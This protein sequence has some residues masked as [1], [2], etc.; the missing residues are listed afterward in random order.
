VLTCRIVVG[1]S[2]EATCYLKKSQN[3]CRQENEQLDETFFKKGLQQEQVRGEGEGED[4]G[5]PVLI[6]NA[7]DDPLHTNHSPSSSHDL[8]TLSHS[9][10]VYI[11]VFNMEY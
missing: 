2:P 8:T 5:G 1:L 6:E 10:Q 3:C 4:E 9:G 11:K 7:I